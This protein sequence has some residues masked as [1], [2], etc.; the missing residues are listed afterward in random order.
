M[1]ACSLG[2]GLRT[3]SFVPLGLA[4]R[5][6]AGRSSTGGLVWETW[7]P[8]RDFGVSGVQCFRRFLAGLVGGVRYSS[9]FSTELLEGDWS[10]SIFVMAVQV[11]QISYA[12]DSIGLM[13]ID[14]YNQP[15]SGM[16]FY[17]RTLRAVYRFGFLIG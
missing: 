3:G 10:T 15:L 14:L 13:K 7:D 6:G 2:L 4:D 9:A 12:K 11:S 16:N 17:Y 5:S 8:T 1:T